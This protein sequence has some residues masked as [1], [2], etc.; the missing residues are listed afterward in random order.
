MWTAENIPDQSG[1]IAIVTGGNSGIGY[2]IATALYLKG[3]NVILAGRNIQALQ[4]ATEN[5]GQVKA[6]GSLDMGIIDLSSLSSVKAFA[7][8]ITGRYNNIDLLIN[9][10]GIMAPPAS[11]TAEGFELQ[12]GV[13]FLA[14]FA[15]TQH[16]YPLLKNTAGSRVV[17]LS[18]GAY[19]MAT[20]IDF[21]NLRS[22]KSYEPYREYA[23][24]K[25]ADLQ[26]M[27]ELQR[28]FEKENAQTISL[29]AHPGVTSTSLSRH[30]S[31]Q[32][33]KSAVEQFGELM[34][35]SQ[36]ALP[37]LYAATQP[38]LIG[39]EYF[40]PDG[41]DE[42]TGYPAPALLNDYAKNEVSA[43]SLWEFAQGMV[44]GSSL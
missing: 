11:K 30:M 4:G 33:Y 31:A 22:E 2:Q 29:G 34:P 32:E 5:I 1:K 13:N 17:T 6:N 15:L 9:N 25:L 20:E 40:G 21:N 44:P 43:T 42:L 26:F 8:D 23:N 35:A 38:G 28:R 7:Q 27:L 37:A 16:L 39:G 10:A 3:A 36:G 19:K 18:S 41:K 14:H 24:S 12:F